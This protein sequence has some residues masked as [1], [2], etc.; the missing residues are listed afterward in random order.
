MTES[1]IRHIRKN[2]HNQRVY[3]LR[4]EAFAAKPL[5]DAHRAF[6]G[7]WAR[8]GCPGGDESQAGRA[9]RKVFRDLYCQYFPDAAKLSAMELGRNLS[10]MRKHPAWTEAVKKEIAI[11]ESEHDRTAVSEAQRIQKM[12]ADFLDLLDKERQVVEKAVDTALK[13]DAGEIPEGA[14]AVMEHGLKVTG[15][16]STTNAEVNVTLNEGKSAEELDE[17]VDRLLASRGSPQ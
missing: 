16:L 13:S 12:R 17:R 7:I 5:S 6:A 2:F 3:R 10:I 11:M 14:K 4:C 8:E 15:L 9:P 1:A